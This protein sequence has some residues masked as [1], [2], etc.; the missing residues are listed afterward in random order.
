MV[1]V[2]GHKRYRDGA[3]RLVVPAPNHPLTGRR[4]NIYETVHAPNNRAS[5]S[6]ADTRLVVAVSSGQ[7]LMSDRRDRPRGRG[8]NV[9]DLARD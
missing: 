6:A 5:A 2:R 8:P 9:A 7:G 3:W 4:R 1:G